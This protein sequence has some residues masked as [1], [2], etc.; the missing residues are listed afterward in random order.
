MAKQKN[1][2]KTENIVRDALRKLGYYEESCGISVEEQKSN[3]EAV[4][5]LLR[6]AS[7]SEHGGRGTRAA[8]LV[9]PD[10]HGAWFKGKEG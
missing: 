8:C 5:R 9:A 1:E 10:G 3:I 2:R 7:K 6:A 4:K